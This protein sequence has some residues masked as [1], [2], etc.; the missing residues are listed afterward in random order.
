[1]FAALYAIFETEVTFLWIFN[2][3][4]IYIKGHVV[5]NLSCV[6][7]Q[8]QIFGLSRS[9]KYSGGCR[10][11][12][13]EWVLQVYSS[14]VGR[15]GNEPLIWRICV[16]LSL[17]ASL[18]MFYRNIFRTLNA[19]LHTTYLLANSTVLKTHRKQKYWLLI[20]NRFYI[21]NYMSDRGT[22]GSRENSIS[23]AKL[24]IEILKQ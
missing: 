2:C 14:N 19:Y 17:C 23:A 24:D 5:W 3:F 13:R 10:A 12:L 16:S 18:Y 9:L 11:L 1:M 15:G 8:M 21:Q 20:D 4:L 22:V 7:N 6:C